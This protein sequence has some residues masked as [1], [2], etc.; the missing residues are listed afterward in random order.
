[1]VPAGFDLAIV[2]Q[3]LEQE[4]VLGLYVADMADGFGK[5]GDFRRT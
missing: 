2:K 4:A 1:M 5:M 3:G